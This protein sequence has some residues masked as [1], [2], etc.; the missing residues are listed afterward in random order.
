MIGRRRYDRGAT[1][2]AGPEG[3]GAAEERETGPTHAAG[4]AN[5]EHHG[6]KRQGAEGGRGQRFA[7][8]RQPQ[9]QHGGPQDLQHRAFPLAEAQGLLHAG[10]VPRERL[11]VGHHP[12]VAS[13][14]WTCGTLGR[15]SYRICARPPRPWPGW[16]RHGAVRGAGSA[17]VIPRPIGQT[18]RMQH[19]QRASRPPAQRRIPGS[20]RATGVGALAGPGRKPASAEPRTASRPRFGAGPLPP[21]S[22]RW[23]ALK[24]KKGIV[25]LWHVAPG[26]VGTPSAPPPHGL[27]RAGA[28]NAPRGA[29]WRRMCLI[30]GPSRAPVR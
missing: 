16:S 29:V 11:G 12:R 7:T 6:E 28:A 8:A 17:S 5:D 2:G 22:K 21:R 27:P 10:H 24:P 30:R 4:G 19:G 23:A 1:A 13:G 18:S 14:D 9:R 3:W 26:L 20:P 25:S 15:P